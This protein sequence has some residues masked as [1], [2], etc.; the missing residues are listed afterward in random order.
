MLSA[1]LQEE[2]NP[3]LTPTANG[4]QQTS[5][6]PPTSMDTYPFMYF[7]QAPAAPP[8]LQIPTIHRL[9]P[10]TGPTHGGI[11]VTVLGANFHANVPLNCV[12]GDVVAS[13]TQRWSENTL[14][15]ILPPRATPGVVAVWI[16]GF[17]KTD[18]PSVMPTSL[19]TY[20]DESD[21]ALCVN[22]LSSSLH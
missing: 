8:A 7:G 20:S 1:V 6:V 18:D 19:F 3:M 12:F 9:I 11:E 14:V 10:N 2:T 5:M 17:A 21:R 4:L 15:C 16:D 22:A 13:S